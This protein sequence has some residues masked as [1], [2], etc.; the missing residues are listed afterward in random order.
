MITIETFHEEARWYRTPFILNASPKTKAG[1]ESSLRNNVPFLLTPEFLPGFSPFF[2]CQIILFR[3]TEALCGIQNPLLERRQTLV[4]RSAY[5]KFQFL[6]RHYF[7][8]SPL[9]VAAASTGLYDSLKKFKLLLQISQ[10]NQGTPI[11]KSDSSLT[12]YLLIIHQMVS[13]IKK[14]YFLFPY[15]PLSS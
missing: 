5:N 1:F 3:S 14:G 15:F 12:K 2:F 7:L 11:C 8:L 4:G 6:L 9:S 13:L 10:H